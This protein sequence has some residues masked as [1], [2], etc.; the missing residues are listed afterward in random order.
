MTQE[1]EHH[2]H[3]HHHPVEVT[4]AGAYVAS[5][6]LNIV[7][8]VAELFAG[9]HL[10]SMSLL[11]DAGH[12]VSDVAGLALALLAHRLAKVKATNSFTYGYKKTTILAALANSVIL[13][14]TVGV[15]GLEAVRRLL[16]P[17]PVEGQGIALVS[18]LGIV[19]NIGSALLFRTSHT[20]DLNTRGAFL[21]LLYDGLVSL[22]VVV[23]GV[24]IKLTGWYVLDGLTSLVIL[25][26][27][28]AGTWGLL[29]RSLTLAL[30]GVPGRI[31]KEAVEAAI[32]AIEGV[33]SV[34]HT[35]IWAMSTTETAL[36]THVVLHP[37]LSFDEKIALVARIKHELLHK[38]I[39]H[40]TV[41]MEHSDSLAHCDDEG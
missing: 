33:Q 27:I 12:N 3:E 17:A 19:V 29:T 21:H 11:A 5:M 38:G 15:L 32:L 37:K 6:A 14:V 28:L 2:H 23:A 25:V 34:K 10:H 22:G 40:A 1:N 35:H 24:L 9:V 18:A 8:V 20:Q 31:H 36:T 7:Y 4:E 39:V 30:D 41:E 13:L 26:V 16:R